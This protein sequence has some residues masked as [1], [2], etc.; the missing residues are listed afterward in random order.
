MVFHHA[1]IAH[2]FIKDIANLVPLVFPT[3]TLIW[4]KMVLSTPNSLEVLQ[5]VENELETTF[6]ESIWQYCFFRSIYRGLKGT[7]LKSLSRKPENF[8]KILISIFFY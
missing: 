7:F 2:I 4:N 1:T 6:S 8:T 3:E 5:L